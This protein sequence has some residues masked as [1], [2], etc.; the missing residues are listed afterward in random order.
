MISFLK[1][2]LLKSRL[3]VTK[4]YFNTVDFTNFFI[5]KESNFINEYYPTEEEKTALHLQYKLKG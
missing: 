5:G 4:D 2:L 3:S 1:V